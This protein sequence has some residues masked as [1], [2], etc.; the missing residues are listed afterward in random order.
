LRQINCAG[1]SPGG[2]L[3]FEIDVQGLEEAY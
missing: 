1:R 2:P 3:E